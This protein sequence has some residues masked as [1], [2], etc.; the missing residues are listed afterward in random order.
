MLAMYLLCNN[1]NRNMFNNAIKRMGCLL[2]LPKHRK[3][4]ECVNI[5]FLLN[6]NPLKYCDLYQIFIPKFVL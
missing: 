6:F 4:K 1:I 5:V 2:E 3:Y